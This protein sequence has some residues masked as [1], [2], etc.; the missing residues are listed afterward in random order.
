MATANNDLFM[1]LWHEVN[2]NYL[3]IGYSSRNEAK[4]SGKNG[5]LIVKVEASESGM[6][7]LNIAL[8]GKTMVK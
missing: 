2:F 1:R 7:I 6:G 3:G 8:I 5:S 4:I